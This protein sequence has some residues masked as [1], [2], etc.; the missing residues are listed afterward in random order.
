MF[1]YSFTDILS[2]L[3]I[4]TQSCSVQT[5]TYENATL[6]QFL[7]NFLGASADLPPCLGGRT[8][9]TCIEVRPILG[10]LTLPAKCIL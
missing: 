4:T 10:R 5:L 7:F 1:I 3:Q 8:Q 2:H 6:T 9:L